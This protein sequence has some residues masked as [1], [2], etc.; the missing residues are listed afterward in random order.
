M[1]DCMIHQPRVG[2]DRE[3]GD[4]QSDLESGP[5]DEAA[6]WKQTPDAGPLILDLSARSKT[7]SLFGAVRG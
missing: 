5:P 1:I 2:P 7:T 3:A 6:G 4:R